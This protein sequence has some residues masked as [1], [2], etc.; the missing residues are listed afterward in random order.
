MCLYLWS[1]FHLSRILNSVR[2]TSYQLSIKT[3]PHRSGALLT[4]KLLLMTLQGKIICNSCTTKLILFFLVGLLF[5]T[6]TCHV[7]WE[8]ICFSISFFCCSSSG[9]KPSVL[10][11]FVVAVPLNCEITLIFFFL[12]FDKRTKLFI[13]LPFLL[14]QFAFCRAFVPSI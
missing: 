14:M 2:F 1:Q 4:L 10:P 8:V 9:S 6:F 7:N 12:F 5:L 13:R 11:D 3:R